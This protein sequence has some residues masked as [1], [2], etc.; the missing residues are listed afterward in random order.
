MIDLD[1]IK[2]RAEAA[3]PGPWEA[4]VWH[5]EGMPYESWCVQKVS[6]RGIRQ[7]WI[8]H[9]IHRDEAKFIAHAREDVP[10]LVAEVKQLR[11]EVELLRNVLGIGGDA[12]TLWGKL[13]RAAE[14]AKSIAE[15]LAYPH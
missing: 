15:L 10:T 8:V 4:R 9:K 6:E 12:T 1:A 11:N 2:A 14:S 3:T 7:D 13:K 5:G